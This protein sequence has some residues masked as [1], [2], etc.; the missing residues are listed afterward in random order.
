MWFISVERGKTNGLS[1]NE[2]PESNFINKEE[3]DEMVC[4]T[5]LLI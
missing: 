5:L 1:E 4:N 3:E 2:A